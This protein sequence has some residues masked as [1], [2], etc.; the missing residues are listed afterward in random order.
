MLK[1]DRTKADHNSSATRKKISTLKKRTLRSQ[2]MRRNYQGYDSNRPEIFPT[3]KGTA[4]LENVSSQMPLSD[5]SRRAYDSIFAEKINILVSYENDQGYPNKISEQKPKENLNTEPI[6]SN[7]STCLA[8]KSK[9]KERLNAQVLGTAQTD[10]CTNAYYLKNNGVT[11]VDPIRAALTWQDDEITGYCVIDPEDDGEGINGIGFR[12]TPTESII[13]M[14]K[15]KKQLAAYRYQEA[16][17]ARSLRRE[18]RTCLNTIKKNSIE[19]RKLTK[20]VRFK[21]AEIKNLPY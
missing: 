20:Q 21:G 13:R 2:S 19:E 7:L 9:A 8:S 1:S 6:S 17:E 16:K 5:D 12:P 11:I 15:R 3:L 4:N 14:E 10:L 18:R